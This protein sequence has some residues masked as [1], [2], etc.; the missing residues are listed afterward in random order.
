MMV[1]SGICW[2]CGPPHPR[3]LSPVTDSLGLASNGGEGSDTTSYERR[4]MKKTWL[5]VLS[6]QVLGVISPPRSFLDTLPEG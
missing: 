1:E 2:I 3:P 6:D 5:D 4:A